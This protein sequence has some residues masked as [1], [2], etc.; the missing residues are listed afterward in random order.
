M[1][2]DQKIMNQHSDL[3]QVLGIFGKIHLLELSIP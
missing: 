2:F 3:R 1:K